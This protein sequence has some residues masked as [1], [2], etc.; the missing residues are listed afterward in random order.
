MQ[1]K[2]GIVLVNYNGAE[3]ITDCMDSLLQQTYKNI[4][5]LFWD[6]HSEDA[7][8]KI[9]RRRYP[10]IQMIAAKRNY[11]FAKA[12]NLAV[13][14]ILKMGAEY[15]LL[16]NVDTVADAYLVERLLCKADSNTV[17]TARIYMENNKKWYAGGELQF[18]SGNAR[19]LCIRGRTEAYQVTFISGCCMMIHKD[20][21]KKYGLF[22]INYYLYYEDTDLCMRWYLEG[23]DMYYIPNAE[24]WHKVRGSSGG[25]DNPLCQYYM[26]RNRLYFVHKYEQYMEVN[27]R[28]V[29]RMLINDKVLHP[30]VYDGMMM[31][32]VCLG[33][34]D[35]YRRKMGRMRYKSIY[36]TM[37]Q[38]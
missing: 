34:I 19:H 31:K 22:D 36:R 9:V 13:K 38:Y 12:N 37:K 26:T 18:D 20:I 32:A 24:L 15:V 30:S 29:L 7:S 35:F 8:V 4:E 17:T 3:Y 23:V 16:L 11:G 25:I 14:Q 10:Q 5:I 33:M 6:N 28:K 1:K 2:V 21:I 27:T